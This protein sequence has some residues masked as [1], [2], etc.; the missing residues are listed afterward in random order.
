MTSSALF[1]LTGRVALVTGGNGGIGLGMAR[2]LA[3]AGADVAIWG[4]NEA[5]NA[6]ASSELSS[7]GEGRVLAV[8]CDVGS[9][10]SVA[11][12]FA[13]TLDALGRVDTCIANAGIG[14]WA[15]SFTDITLEDWREV[16]RVNMEGAF[17]TLRAAAAH[18]VERAG[19]GDGGGSLIGVAS[20]A[21]IEGAARHQHYAATKGGLVS[22][23]KALAV[24]YARHGI[25]ANAVLPGWIETAM[26]DDVFANQRFRDNVLP[27]IPMRR[28][29][30]PEDFGG[31]AVY[32]ASDA[33]A[34]HTG[35]TLLID[36]GY[37]I[38]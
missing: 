11:S 35:D 37:A 14:K 12:A 34:Y 1:D 3:Q 33:S 21:A 26:T 32:L 15:R 31:I 20:L 17:L 29:G 36:G 5:K 4:T 9:E 27:R 13:E 6:A 28:W 18:M 8:R 16:M 2:A 22:M 30:R 38:F 10:S 19:A 7:V 24:E 25:R 23:M